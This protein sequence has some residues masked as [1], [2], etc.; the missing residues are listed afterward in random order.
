MDC[1]DTIVFKNCEIA[2]SIE[3]QVCITDEG[4]LLKVPVTLCN[5][6]PCRQVI[7]GVRICL[8]GKFYAMK[9]KEVFTGGRE[10]CR[11]IRELFVGDFNFLFTH[12]C[13]DQVDVE[14]LAHYICKFV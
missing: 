13:E 9:T 3:K 2:K 7:V 1:N 11:R 5:V 10:Y 12:S 8:N 6:H 4:H 14:V